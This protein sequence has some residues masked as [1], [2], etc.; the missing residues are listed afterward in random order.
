MNAHMKWKNWCKQFNHFIIHVIF[1]TISKHKH[2]HRLPN[3]VNFAVTVVFCCHEHCCRNFSGIVCHMEH[4]L[5]LF[6]GLLITSVI[7]NLTFLGAFRAF[8]ETV[9]ERGGGLG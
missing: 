8:D 1:K 6:A 9:G 2:R 5:M 3:K 4:F 7:P